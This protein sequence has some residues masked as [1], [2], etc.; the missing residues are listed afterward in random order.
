MTTRITQLKGHAS[1]KTT[2][3]V[4]GSLH[5]EDAEVLEETYANLRAENVENIAIDLSNISL[6]IVKAH[7]SYAAFAS[8]AWS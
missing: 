2:L 5:R 7:P 6:W 8:W 3:R 4:E 1:E